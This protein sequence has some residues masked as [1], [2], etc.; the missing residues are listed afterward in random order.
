M[1]L[2]LRPLTVSEFLDRTFSIYRHRFLL[3]VGLMAPQAVT[4][5]ATSLIANWLQYAVANPGRD[6]LTLV[7][8]LLIG[9]SLVLILML[10]HY[11]VYAIGTG[12]A[13]AAV[14]T[15]Y[16]RL[17]PDF[18]SSYR[19]AW[20]RVGPLLWLTFLIALRIAAVM[21]LCMVP[22]FAL[23]IAAAAMT[24]GGASGAAAG[25]ASVLLMLLAMLVAFVTV[26]YLIL[27]Y[28]V[29]LPSLMLE[30]IGARAAIRRSI[31]LMRGRMLAG[32]LLT[33][34][35]VA[36]SVAASAMLQTPFVAGSLVAG[37]ETRTGFLLTMI[38]T[39]TGSIGQGLTSPLIVIGMAVLYFDARVRHE[40]LDLQIMTDALAPPD[41]P[42]APGL[43]P[44]APPPL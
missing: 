2:D 39:V 17:E 14:S 43:A 35:T 34:C 33:F 21:L 26:V 23:I 12:A 44:V 40:A 30:S 27:R 8:P 5:M 25:I 1:N 32:L 4:A 36:V 24:S 31:A 41:P 18:A 7:G 10:V 28:A 13:V 6:P 38:G 19:A 15:L 9:G 11:A 29:A 16:G 20:H 22:T 37:P 3:F 42:P